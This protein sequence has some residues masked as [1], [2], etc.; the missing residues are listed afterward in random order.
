MGKDWEVGSGEAEISLDTGVRREILLYK[1]SSLL[2]DPCSFL[3]IPTLASGHRYSACCTFLSP[4]IDPFGMQ[5]FRNFRRLFGGS[6]TLG[7]K[8]MYPDFMWP[9]LYVILEGWLVRKKHTK[10]ETSDFLLRMDNHNLHI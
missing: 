5:L 9:T 2:A 3:H 10:L 4:S 6:R 1:P 8:K 7:W